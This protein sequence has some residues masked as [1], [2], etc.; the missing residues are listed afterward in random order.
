LTKN[1]LEQ[2]GLLS[3]SVAP[4]SQVPGAFQAIFKP[5]PEKPAAGEPGKQAGDIFLEKTSDGKQS[6]VVSLGSQSKRSAETF[7]QAGGGLARWLRQVGLTSIDIDLVTLDTLGVPEAFVALCE[8]LCLGS[9]QFDRY[10]SK[11]ES[12]LTI[13]VVLRTDKD[14]AEIELMVKD[15]TAL[16]NA[17][18][19]ARD[20]AHEPPNE[21]NPISLA[22]RAIVVAQQFGLKCTIIDDKA[23][24]EMNAGGILNVGKGSAT[25][26]RMIILEY[27]GNG[28]SPDTQPVVLVGKALTFDTGGYSLKGVDHIQ[29]MKYDKCGGLAVIGALRAA[30]EL[31]LKI[32]V[33]GIIGA[34][35]NKISS[36]SY[37]PDDIITTL[38]GLTVEIISTDAEGRMVLADCLT[39]AQQ[40]FH[41]SAIID[42]ATLTGAVVI[43]LGHVRA[44][45]MSNNDNLSQELMEAGDR[46]YERL[47]RLPLDEEYVKN[48]KGDDSDL[49]NSGGREA[50]TIAGGTFLHQFV[51]DDVPWAHLDIAGMADTTKELPYCPKGGTGFGVRL[52]VNYLQHLNP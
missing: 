3:F 12:P 42:L 22:E 18:N 44:G 51:S 32:P 21:I 34:A 29:G 27:S 17:V 23:L 37:L 25:P 10:K 40:K 35:E 26:S 6:V 20:W 19:M 36:G 43:A 1:Y 38:S 48:I 11:Q 41:P 13:Q 52:L 31:Q 45:L 5:A 30:S 16:T 14:Q 46:T 9:F 4:I 15:I 50:G 7:R 8:G 33:V 49:K 2:P 24:A 39:Y 28:V 47:W